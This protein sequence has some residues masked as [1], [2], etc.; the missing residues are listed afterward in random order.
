MS[1]EKYFLNENMSDVKLDIDGKVIPCHKIILASS[2]THFKS[3]FDNVDEK[4]I[5]LPNRFDY[6]IT[7]VVIK[8]IYFNEIFI[9]DIPDTAGSK[10]HIEKYIDIICVASY[11]GID[12][13]I[14]KC[15]Y[16]FINNTSHINKKISNDFDLKELLNLL[17]LEDIC[18]NKLDLFYKS[19]SIVEPDLINRINE[20]S[21]QEILKLYYHGIINNYEFDIIPQMIQ[22]IKDNKKEED[23][24]DILSKTIQITLPENINKNINQITTFCKEEEKEKLKVLLYDHCLK[25]RP[26]NFSS[27]ENEICISKTIVFQTKKIYKIKYVY[28]PPFDIFKSNCN[29]RFFCNTGK[30][31]KKF[32]VA[33]Y[34][35]HTI[36]IKSVVFLHPFNENKRIEFNINQLFVNGDIHCLFEFSENKDT[37]EYD[38]CP[39]NDYVDNKNQLNVMFIVKK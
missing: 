1:F 8:F 22:W 11:F 20:I 33:C 28:G 16:Y 37:Y 32:S 23:T 7:L 39:Y 21:Y 24:Y 3:L 10:T 17:K 25:L 31:R 13:L 2:S 26:I 14:D 27:N 29:I 12:K 9:H 34:Y 4:I 6:H 15:C 5:K 19:F 18:G 36:R 35:E 30:S 38:D